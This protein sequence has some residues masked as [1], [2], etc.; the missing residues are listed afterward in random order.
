MV[1]NRDINVYT[2]SLSKYLYSSIF[3]CVF[4]SIFHLHIMLLIVW[5]LYYKP[6]HLLKNKQKVWI[7]IQ[8]VFELE[9]NMHRC[10]FSE[11]F[12]LEL[13]RAWYMSSP[14]PARFL[15]VEPKLSPSLQKLGLEPVEPTNIWRAWYFFLKTEKNGQKSSLEPNWA[16]QLGSLSFW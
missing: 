7:N 12:Y 16:W 10:W 14:S 11:L 4:V 9:T 1:F 15:K 3:V 13:G 6:N 2:A 5:L 8:I